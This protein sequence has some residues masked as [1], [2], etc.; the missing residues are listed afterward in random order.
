MTIHSRETYEP[1]NVLHEIQIFHEEIPMGEFPTLHDRKKTTK[2]HIRPY[3]AMVIWEI[4]LRLVVILM[5]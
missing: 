1:T 2:S 3:K 5:C 4:I